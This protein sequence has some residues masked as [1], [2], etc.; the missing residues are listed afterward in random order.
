MMSVIRMLVVICLANI[1]CYAK[2]ETTTGRK[3]VYMLCVTL[4]KFVKIYKISAVLHFALD[5][6][7]NRSDILSGYDL[8]IICGFSDKIVS[9]I[10]LFNNITMLM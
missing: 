10:M 3:T 4:D 5:V 8:Q 9:L 6:V 2:N 1:A 7:N